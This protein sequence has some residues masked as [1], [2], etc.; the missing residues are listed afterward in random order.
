MALRMEKA[1]SNGGF[2]FPAINKFQQGY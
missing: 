2:I 1:C